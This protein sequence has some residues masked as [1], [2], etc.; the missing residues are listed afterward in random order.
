MKKAEIKR[1]KRV[2]PA[3]LQQQNHQPQTSP[4]QSDVMEEDPQYHS[5]SRSSV[6]PVIANG[7]MQEDLPPEQRHPG[8]IPVDFTDSFRSIN[9]P[10]NGTTV[11][12]KRSFSVTER[13]D[14]IHH[15]YPH[16]QNVSTPP[17]DENIDPS[18]P[19]T[20]QGGDSDINEKEAKRAELRREAERFR[21]M[22]IEK[23]RELA[24]LG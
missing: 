1:R 14:R 5:D 22:M 10:Q 16:A 20:G 3:N 17:T 15:P 9:P 8:P 24:E 7:Q 11:P 13:E 2:V 23:E 12:R 4:Y 19:V 18:L 6:P 21:Q